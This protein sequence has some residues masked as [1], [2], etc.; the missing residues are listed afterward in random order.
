[1]IHPQNPQITALPFKASVRVRWEDPV[2]PPNSQ[3]AKSRKP[4]C[5]KVGINLKKYT[6]RREGGMRRE[7]SSLESTA[8]VQIGVVIVTSIINRH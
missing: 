6:V 1:V 8:D 4:G 7:D 5:R 3:P 2:D